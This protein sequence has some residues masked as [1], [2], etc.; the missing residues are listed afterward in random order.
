M[1]EKETEIRELTR[2]GQFL[3]SFVLATVWLIVALFLIPFMVLFPIFALFMEREKFNDLAEIT[4]NLFR[5]HL[6][7]D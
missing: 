5:I 4:S 7:E 6:E 2:F 1:S 3:L